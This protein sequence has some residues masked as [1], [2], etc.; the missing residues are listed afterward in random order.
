MTNRDMPLSDLTNQPKRG[1]RVCAVA[2]LPLLGGKEFILPTE[3]KPFR[4]MVFRHA[5]TI[6]AYINGCKHFLGTPLNPNNLGNFLH[7]QDSSLIRCGVHGALYHLATGA[8][9]QGECDGVG[10]DGVPV[11]VREGE[12]FIGTDV[13][14]SI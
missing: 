5:G 11:H 1:T 9:A 4:M 13:E 2:D 10:L 12:V 8:C 7:P 3:G 6:L 14:V